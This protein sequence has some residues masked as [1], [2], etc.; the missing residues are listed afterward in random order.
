MA[1]VE[2][3]MVNVEHLSASAGVTSDGRRMTALRDEG[4][5]RDE[6]PPRL[7]LIRVFLSLLIGFMAGLVGWMAVV[8]AA[9]LSQGPIAAAARLPMLTPWAQGIAFL[10]PAVVVGYWL[11]MTLG[12]SR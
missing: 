5:M 10:G 12:S 4:K 8:M 7:G 2:C 9:L 3:W 1:S 11:F 6:R